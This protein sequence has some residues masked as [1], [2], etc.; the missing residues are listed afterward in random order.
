MAFMQISDNIQVKWVKPQFSPTPG[1]L[2]HLEKNKQT[3][4]LTKK[5]QSHKLY[6]KFRW[7]TNF[8]KYRENL[9]SVRKQS[10]WKLIAEVQYQTIQRY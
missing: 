2:E 4:I 10:K 7:K 1:G 9:L 3:H 5:T 8:S 6:I